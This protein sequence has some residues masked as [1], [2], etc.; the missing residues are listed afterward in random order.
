M[1]RRSLFA[2][3]CLLAAQAAGAGAIDKL[4]QFLESTR[5]VRADFTQTV[6][7]RNGRQAWGRKGCIGDSSRES[8]HYE[9]MS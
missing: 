9:H 5:T 7:A 8:A 2:A 4:H 1:I 6:I 3:A